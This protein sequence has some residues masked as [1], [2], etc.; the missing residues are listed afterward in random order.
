MSVLTS[1][2]FLIL[3]MLILAFL[4]LVPGLFVLFSHYKF[5]QFAKNKA[6]DLTIFFILGAETS[7]ILF[8][9]A[10]Y[11]IICSSPALALVI[12]SD[13]F[14]WIMAGI[15]AALAILFFCIYYRPGKGSQ[16][17]ISRSFASHCI[18]RAQTAKTRSESFLVGLFAGIP[19]L[20]FTLPLYF[21]AA[22]SIMQLG[23]TSFERAGLIILL[24]FSAIS[25]LL[26]FHA[27]SATGRTLADFAKFRSQNKSFFRFIIPLFYLFIAILM[28]LGVLL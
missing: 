15:F 5:G 21:L 7:V 1:L 20:I 13:L 16:L 25:P 10:I 19:E 6:S 8:F 17:F 9:L 27:L 23:A 2:S 3:V 24:A 11:V 14:A 18:K 28:V 12:D 26:I 22:I 4:Q